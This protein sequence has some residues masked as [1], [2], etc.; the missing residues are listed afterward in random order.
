MIDLESIDF[1]QVPLTP[2][3]QEGHG[4]TYTSQSFWH[5]IKRLKFEYADVMT[6]SIGD[7]PC[8]IPI[9]RLIMGRPSQGRF[10]KKRIPPTLGGYKIFDDLH[11]KMV[12]GY[13]NGVGLYVYV[14]SLNLCDSSSR[15]LMVYIT[16]Q[17]QSLALR[18]YFNKLWNL[19]MVPIYTNNITKGIK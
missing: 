6:F 7:N 10:E 8:H 5:K 11:A 2:T 12:I 17:E 19:P 13:N 18:N 3:P 15:E 4:I 9:R 14:G 1:S 16:S